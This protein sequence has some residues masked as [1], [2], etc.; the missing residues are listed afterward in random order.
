MQRFPPI[1]SRSCFLSAPPLSPPT[2]VVIYTHIYLPFLARVD[3]I[4]KMPQIVC[5]FRHQYIYTTYFLVIR[6]DPCPGQR[7]NSY[8][9][10][11]VLRC[12]ASNRVEYYLDTTVAHQIHHGRSL[13]L[14]FPCF[15]LYCPAF[16]PENMHASR[17]NAVLIA[18]SVGFAIKDD[19][20][21][22]LNDY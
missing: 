19:G 12:A 17:N 11:H 16:H 1:E 7:K 15:F 20:S 10:G 8:V 6:H 4:Q 9:R 13:P 5:S 18:A 22:S 3:Y 14:T 21:R 2:S